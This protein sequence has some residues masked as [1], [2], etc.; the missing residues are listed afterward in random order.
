MS[1][2]KTCR[3]CGATITVGADEL[4]EA[5]EEFLAET[6]EPCPMGCGRT[7]DDRKTTP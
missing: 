3:G 4:C 5:C 6:P 7:T 1:N 2:M